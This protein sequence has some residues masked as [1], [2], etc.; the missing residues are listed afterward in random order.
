[1]Y[2][3]DALKVL[4]ENTTH[5]VGVN[6]FIDYGSTMNARWVDVLKPKQEEE[7][8]DRPCTEIVHEIWE[9]MRNGQ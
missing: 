2:V 9:R 5:F 8:D 1:M 6:E 4:T 7:E 3:T